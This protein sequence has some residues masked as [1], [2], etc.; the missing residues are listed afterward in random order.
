MMSTFSLKEDLSGLARTVSDLVGDE[1]SKTGTG[2]DIT[3]SV[4]VANS[5]PPQPD[6]PYAVVFHGMTK[7][8]GHGKSG[9]SVSEDGSHSID[10]F[11]KIVRF[12]VNFY[13]TL[14]KDC[15]SVAEQFKDLIQIDRGM[16]IFCNYTGGVIYRVS[17]VIYDSVTLNT[18]YR[19][20]ATLTVEMSKRVSYKDTTTGFITST[21]VE[22]E[23]EV[24]DGT[25][26]EADVSAP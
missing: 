11:D 8:V 4:F 19:E 10:T 16:K 1:L 24:A 18:S 7:S 17:D 5:L 26:I 23:L 21:T 12:T 2:P 9:S 13:G 20:V 15:L 22:G 25:L 6:Y 14:D 3:P